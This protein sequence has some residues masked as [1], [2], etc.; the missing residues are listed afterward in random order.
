MVN[1]INGQGSLNKANN[2]YNMEFMDDQK[3]IRV[4]GTLKN[5]RI[6]QIENS[7]FWILEY[8]ENGR[9]KLG[10]LEEIKVGG[11]V[12]LYKKYGVEFKKETKPMG[13]QDA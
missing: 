8:M 1:E 4:I 13:F 11:Q 6:L 5:S 12:R 3:Q 9:K 2:A 7:T 10:F